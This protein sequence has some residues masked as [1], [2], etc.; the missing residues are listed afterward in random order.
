MKV[1]SQS[2]SLV[3]LLT[4]APLCL[5][6]QPRGRAQAPRPVTPATGRPVAAPQGVTLSAQDLAYLLDSLNP[7]PEQR[8]RF[9]ASAAARKAFIQDA[10]EMF[11]VAEA[12][13]AAGLAARPDVRFQSEL[14]RAFVIARAYTL[15]RQA[16]GAVAPEQI[17]SAAESAAFM[18]EPG[19]EQRFAEFLADYRKHDPA[20]A[21]AP[22]TAAQ[23]AQLKQNWVQV[24][25]SS[26]KGSALGLDSVRANVVAIM[27]QQARLLASAYFATTLKSQLVVTEPELDVYLT[28]HPELDPKVARA[29]I[30]SV[31][32]R[33]RAGED[34]AALAREFSN[35][36]G[37]KDNGGDLGWFARGMMVKPFE[38]A[39]FALKDGEISNVVESPF[40]FHLIKLEARRMQPGTGGQAAVEEVHARHILIAPGGD[41]GAQQSPREQARAAIEQTKQSALIAA[42]VPRAHV[43]LPD[44][45]TVDATAVAP[46]E[47]G[48]PAASAPP[49][50]TKPV[51]P[52]RGHTNPVRKP[53]RRP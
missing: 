31:L 11:A 12:G 7:P 42:L 28:Q 26:R 22:L 34:F 30:D 48:P 17:V 40:G 4:L 23:L 6:A 43:N 35:D 44:D 53:G 45:F 50:K 33:A 21:N 18:K 29:Q 3:A 13:R 5:H 10:R 51:A 9:A 8:A 16:E 39:A 46:D 38:D 24:L 14:S 47:A 41:P 37:S 2:L 19:Q 49:T 1:F 20:G 15:K 52:P 32:Q 25:I 27:Y 36:P